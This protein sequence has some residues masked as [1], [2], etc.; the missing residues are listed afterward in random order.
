MID[1]LGPE[2]CEHSLKQMISKIYPLQYDLRCT[3]MIT[4]L[5]SGAAT[6]YFKSWLD[7]SARLNWNDYDFVYLEY[8]RY[9]FIARQVKNK[10]RKLVIRVHNVEKDYFS[11]QVT[12]KRN[13]SNF[14]RLQIKRKLITR[15]ES[16]SLS[17]ADLAICLTAA[18]AARLTELYPAETADIKMSVIP[19]ALE[20]PQP[21]N[22]KRHLPAGEDKKEDPYLLITGSLWY[23]PNAESTAWFIKNVWLKLLEE[24]HFLSR[25]Y[26]LLIAGSKAGHTIKTLSAS[27]KSIKLIDSPENIKPYLERAAI[28]IAPVFSGAGMKVRVAEALSYGIPVIGTGSALTGYNIVNRISGYY[29]ESANDFIAVL[30]HFTRLT[31]AEKNIIKA[32]AYRLFLDNHSIEESKKLFRQAIKNL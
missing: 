30:E 19:V 29:A 16:I 2:I 9:G 11:N 8:S 12:V 25:K 4:A 21:L 23:G 20:H 10:F 6:G 13:L 7:T 28:Y 32:N 5:F 14:L 27:H 31:A 24:D 1:Y 22:K 3:G 26:T 17:N 18:D 15:Q